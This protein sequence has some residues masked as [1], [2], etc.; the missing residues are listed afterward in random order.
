MWI[1]NDP[2]GP[3]LICAAL[4]ASLKFQQFRV[5]VCECASSTSEMTK[6]TSMFFL[7]ISGSGMVLIWSS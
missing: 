6:R 5:F 1:T 7:V 2:H 4:S 3:S